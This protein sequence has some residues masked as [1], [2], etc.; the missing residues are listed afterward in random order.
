MIDCRK[1]GFS[2]KASMRHALI[3]NCCPA[4]GSAIMGDT[5]TQRM[6]L[7]KQRLMSQEFSQALSDEIIFDISLFMLLEFTSISSSD[8][9][10]P[11]G[12]EA[13]ENST[14]EDSDD[15]EKI[16]DEIRDEVMAKAPDSPEEVNED[17]KIARLKRLAKESKI[18]KSGT[19]VR[20][21][22]N[23]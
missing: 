5:H 17:L 2:I 20:R 10:S 15:Y 3:E 8:D 22:G 16:R 21:I 23:D 4:C 13:Q 11:K 14:T 6:R 1:C 18:K 9:E 19:A 12:T 7:M